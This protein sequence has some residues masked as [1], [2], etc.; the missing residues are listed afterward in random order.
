MKWRQEGEW[1]KIKLEKMKKNENQIEIE[2]IK[3]TEKKEYLER[4]DPN[5][6]ERVLGVRL[7]LTGEMNEELKY[8]KK[9]KELLSEVIQFPSVKS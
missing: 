4:L 1:G 7:P 8:R 2:H 9:L 3:N 5:Q 6:A